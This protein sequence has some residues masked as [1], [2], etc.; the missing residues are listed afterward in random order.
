MAL[1]EQI[2]KDLF[3]CKYN[4]NQLFLFKYSAMSDYKSANQAT[5]LRNNINIGQ[6]EYYMAGDTNRHMSDCRFRLT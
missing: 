3:R 5:L 2:E 6:R 4:D 1:P